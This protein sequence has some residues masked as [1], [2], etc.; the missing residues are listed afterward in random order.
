[1]REVAFHILETSRQG[2]RD[3]I[4]LGERLGFLRPPFGLLQK[5]FRCVL[6]IGESDRLILEAVYP[7][8]EGRRIC[9]G[10]RSGPLAYLHSKTG[11]MKKTEKKEDLMRDLKKSTP[12]SPRATSS[13]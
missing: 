12:P 5:G 4:V 13:I 1:M 8:F 9:C 2:G 11:Q 6:L 10:T 3:E 7:I